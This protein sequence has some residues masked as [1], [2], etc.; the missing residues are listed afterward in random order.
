MFIFN[1]KVNSKKIIW[2]RHHF[3]C[4]NTTAFI[5]T[6]VPSYTYLRH[7][8]YLLCVYELLA[9]QDGKM[10]YLLN[11]VMDISIPF[12]ICTCIGKVIKYDALTLDVLDNS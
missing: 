10:K 5:V 12:A 6:V 4:F 3:V 1:L 2:L 9:M 11:A 8:V 7:T